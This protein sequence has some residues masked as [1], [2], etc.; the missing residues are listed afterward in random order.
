[1]TTDNPNQPAGGAGGGGGS[2][3]VPTP[4][5]Q[6]GDKVDYS[7]YK[8]AM[9][10][11][12]KLKAELGRVT[13]QLKSFETEKEKAQKKKL[14]EQGE[15]QKLA[16]TARTEAADWKTKFEGLNA[17]ILDSKKA[18]A[19]ASRLPGTLKSDFY[20]MLNIDGVAVT[21]SGEIDE[22]SAVKAAE[23]F[24]KKYPEL[25]IPRDTPNLP[26]GQ[27]KGKGGLSYE[28]WV[29]LPYAEKKKR[30]GEVFK[31]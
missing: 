29:G 8:R 25:I 3:G 10:D 31:L 20:H 16:E 17:Q 4:N 22:T 19:I 26:N 9:D 24:A 12:A 21:E 15:W 14:E 1:M 13:D 7:T 2:D 28:E 6:P 30:M 18:N 11:V 27:P 23:D 5:G